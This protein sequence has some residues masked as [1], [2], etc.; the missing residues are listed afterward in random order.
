MT[1]VGQAQRRDV[2]CESESETT[3][4]RGIEGAEAGKER[5][6]DP[7]TWGQGPNPSPEAHVLR[8]RTLGAP[9]GVEKRRP[10]QPPWCISS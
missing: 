8:L 1:E 9:E 3:T 2:R 10:A 4:W 6:R 7:G 5:A